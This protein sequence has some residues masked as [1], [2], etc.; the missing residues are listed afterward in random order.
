MSEAYAP[1]GY[2]E[3]RAGGVII[4]AISVL[5]AILLV[6]GLAYAAGS[7]ARH[8]AALAAAG[9]EPNLSHSGLPCTTVQM[10][11][12]QYAAITTPVIQQMNADL[13]AYTASERG[14]LP[15]AEAA[16]T[17]EV[18]AENAFGASLARFP[19]PPAVAAMGRTLT[20]ANQASATLTAEQAHAPSLS[21]L[22]SFNGRVAAADAAVQADIQLVSKALAAPPAAGQE[23]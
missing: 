1:D 14:R 23:P 21:R 12:A 13:A 6:A 8:K 16:L 4:I 18:T 10:L 3:T 2:D 20:E 19:F 5:S 22:R 17:A 15:A 7:G 11:T 9:C